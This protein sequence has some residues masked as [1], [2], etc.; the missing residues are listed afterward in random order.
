MHKF[1]QICVS[2]ITSIP[3]TKVC[4]GFST[5]IDVL[6]ISSTYLLQRDEILKLAESC[7]AHEVATF[8]RQCYN[9]NLVIST[10]Y[11]HYHHTLLPLLL[12]LNLG[13]GESSSRL[14]AW[15][16]ISFP[17]SCAKRSTNICKYQQLGTDTCIHLQYF[18]Y[19]CT[20]LWDCSATLV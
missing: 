8:L 5:N 3:E 4:F 18:C 20:H 1:C 13:A 11:S 19:V 6:S 2:C 16:S 17:F 12:M 9:D 15:E 7:N 10:A 14:S